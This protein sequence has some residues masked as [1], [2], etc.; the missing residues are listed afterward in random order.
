MPVMSEMQQRLLDEMRAPYPKCP[1][2][3]TPTESNP[4]YIRNMSGNVRVTLICPN[5]DEP[6]ADGHLVAETFL[7]PDE[8]HKL[9]L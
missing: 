2:C 6:H 3:G 8:V 7:R 4:S 1:G 9:G 5:R